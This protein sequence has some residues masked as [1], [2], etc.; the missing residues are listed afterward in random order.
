M[1]LGFP[2]LAAAAAAAAGADLAGV[3][4]AALDAVARTT[5]CFYVDTLEFLRRGGRI[6]AAEALLGTALSVKPI[7]HM[8]DG[9]DRAAGQGAYRQPGRGPPGRPG[10][11]GGR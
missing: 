7:M 2:A 10:R 11:R 5:V 8:P 3:R 4:E 1:G 6:N 9:D